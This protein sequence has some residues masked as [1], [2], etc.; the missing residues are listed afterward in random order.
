MNARGFLLVLAALA[1][2]QGCRSAPTS[3]DSPEFT[4][5]YRDWDYCRL[6]WTRQTHD[7]SCGAACLSSVLAY[8]DV[9]ITE[10]EIVLH[11]PPRDP[12]LAPGQGYTLLDLKRIAVS[13]GREAFVLSMAEDPAGKLEAQVRKGRPVILAV[14]WPI[15]ENAGRRVPV[16]GAAFREFLRSRQEGNP[17]LTRHF[18]VVFGIGRRAG[19]FLIMDPIVGYRVMDTAPLLAAWSRT[20]YSALL[21]GSREPE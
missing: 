19:E 3:T 9:P 6:R 5:R 13:R 2:F 16:L 21:C 7:D 1:G 10:A 12:H 14:E 15:T 8:W 11:H 4:A 18:L 20:R 17:P